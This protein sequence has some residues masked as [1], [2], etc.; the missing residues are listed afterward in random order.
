[1]AMTVRRSLRMRIVVG[2]GRLGRAFFQFVRLGRRVTRPPLIAAQQRERRFVLLEPQL[3]DRQ[4]RGTRIVDTGRLERL[5][6]PSMIERRL[7]QTGNRIDQHELE[8]FRP[9]LDPIPEPPIPGKP[10]RLDPLPKDSPLRPAP[11]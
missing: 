7:P 4:P 9:D 1:M 3:I 6:Q 10:I 8:P 5:G 2:R 11:K